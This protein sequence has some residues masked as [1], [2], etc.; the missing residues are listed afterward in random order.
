MITDLPATNTFQPLLLAAGS[1]AKNYNISPAGLHPG[2]Q[3]T[4]YTNAGRRRGAGGC[5]CKHMKEEDAEF[6]RRYGQLSGLPDVDFVRAVHDSVEQ[7]HVQL[8]VRRLLGDLAPEYVVDTK[9]LEASLELLERILLAYAGLS[10]DTSEPTALSP[11]GP[12]RS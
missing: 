4:C 7:I 1:A 5:I 3:T 6:N 11:P 12:R 10:G 8:A 9:S 2:Q